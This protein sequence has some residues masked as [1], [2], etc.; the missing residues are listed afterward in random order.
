M[1]ILIMCALVL[2]ELNRIRGRPLTAEDKSARNGMIYVAIT[3]A[4]LITTLMPNYIYRN[5]DRRRYPD[6]DAMKIFKLATKYADYSYGLL[7]IIVYGVLSTSYRSE[8]K[9]IL[10]CSFRRVEPSRGQATQSVG[11]A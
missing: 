10:Q 1:A 2:I 3:F 4:V 7:N 6:K 8:I 9:S 11:H 5:V